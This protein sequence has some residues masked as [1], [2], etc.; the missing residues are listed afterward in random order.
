MTRGMITRS[1]NQ[2]GENISL[3]RRAASTE[4][5][6]RFVSLGLIIGGGMHTTTV[7]I[8]SFDLLGRFR[9]V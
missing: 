7:L 1:S 9:N 8:Y 3:M 6:G 4:I 2:S 5:P